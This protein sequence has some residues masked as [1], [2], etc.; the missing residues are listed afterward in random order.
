MF[1]KKDFNL[2]LE[3][4]LDKIESLHYQEQFLEF[5]PDFFSKNLPVSWVSIF[6]LDH[7]KTAFIEFLGEKYPSVHID[8]LTPDSSLP[9]F[10]KES[11]RTVILKEE[12]I[13]LIDS[14]KK[15]TSDLFEKLTVDIVI[16]MFSLETFFGFIVI[17]AEKNTYKE[18]QS[19]NAF[20]KIFS[21]MIYPLIENERIDIESDKNY[22]KIFRMDR[23]VTAGEIAAT[24]AHE[25][26]NPLAG[27]STYLRYLFELEDFN[28][29]DVV[30]ELNTLGQSVKRI[31]EIADSLSC[32]YRYTRK[33]IERFSLTEL[34]ESSL[35][36]IRLKIY[37]GIHIKKKMDKT[38]FVITD[39]Q[40]LKQVVINI[41][42]NAAEAIGKKKGEIVIQTYVTGRDQLPSREMYNISITD[43]GPGIP[44][45]MSGSLFQPF[46]TTK[47]FGTGLGLY[48]C[49]GLMKSMGGTITIESPGIGTGVII[50][51]PYSLD[52]DDDI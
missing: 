12:E 45:E 18:I 16:P 8:S 49:Y 20:F 27:I 36:A 26:K 3:Q 21:N 28:K 33:K 9:L 51:L 40:Q 13:S 46:R 39:F 29:N 11:K 42:L 41:L 4:T 24:A 35:S 25:I 22:Y 10:L 52:E 6:V 1:F 5:A 17:E 47:E 2:L 14:F 43:N 19:L 30:N 15:S 7:E 23:L 38:L 34:I 32:F 44:A 37:P 31:G 50:S 48:T